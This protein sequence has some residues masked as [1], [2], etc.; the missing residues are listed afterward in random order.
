MTSLEEILARDGVLVYKTR[1]TSMEPLLRQ[2]R[3]LVIIRAPEAR[4]KKGDVALYR[5]GESYVLHRVIEV[6]D[7]H[8]LIRGDNTFAPEKVPCGAVIGVMTGFRRKGREY[9]A[10]DAGY[11]RYV[12]VWNALYPLRLA[13]FCLIRGL[14][15]AARK[16]G[17]T[18]LIK[19][20][21]RY[22]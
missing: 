21:L 8:Y 19:R 3:D 5:R 10:A 17:L 22:E 12:R 13:W 4:L 16:L 15:A 20:L 2:D 11:L 9:G 14:K 1:G 6:R 18:R 7:D